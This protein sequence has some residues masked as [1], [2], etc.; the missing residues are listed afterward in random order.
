MLLPSRDP[1]TIERMIRDHTGYSLGSLKV[2]ESK[3]IIK[4]HNEIG[5][6][7]TNFQCSY[8]SL[9]KGELAE[10]LRMYL[11]YLLNNGVLLSPTGEPVRS[12]N[13]VQA[14]ASAPAPAPDPAF[15]DGVP[16][17]VAA[18]ISALAHSPVAASTPPTADVDFCVPIHSMWGESSWLSSGKDKIPSDVQD[19]EGEQDNQNHM[20]RRTME[21]SMPSNNL[22]VRSSLRL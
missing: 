3:N 17:P 1:A 15:I 18:D 4:F 11:D 5:G 8:S 16:A 10:V 6:P 22:N 13:P 19:E 20:E 7:P 2:A 12:L 14:P 21:N 9:K